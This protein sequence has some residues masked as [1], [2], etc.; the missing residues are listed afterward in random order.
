M[1]IAETP[2][3]HTP[4]T[5]SNAGPIRRALG[6]I[7]RSYRL[8][9]SKSLEYRGSLL[10][11]AIL[12]GAPLIASYV[13]WVAVFSTKPEGASVSG[14]TFPVLITYQMIAHLL[15]S[16]CTG[17]SVMHTITEEI[18]NGEMNR[19]LVRPVPYGLYRAVAFCGYNTVYF[20]ILILPAATVL[21]LLG[22][23]F[24]FT[25]WGNVALG[26]AAMVIG[27]WIQYL[28]VYLFSLL[29]F[30]L[31]EVAALFYVYIIVSKFAS[32]EMVPVD[33]FPAWLIAI[34]E[35][36][37]FPSVIWF[38]LQIY[39][40]RLDGPAIAHGFLVGASWLAILILFAR[41]MWKRGI[42]RY[43]AYGG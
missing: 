15:Y 17:W 9:L 39:L 19:Y 30:W 25:N 2:S 35:W 16:L 40:D 29:A 18:R 1:S 34:L 26:T 14:Y 28:I 31:D 32:G 27:Y 3:F 42:N 21:L 24:V 12:G 43:C 8:E 7:S 23:D 36:T 33:M 37:P 22:D 38:P 4:I 20:V 41:L 5:A 11:W 10:G 6:F 13:L